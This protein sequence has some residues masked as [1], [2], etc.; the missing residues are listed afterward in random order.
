MCQKGTS[1]YIIRRESGCF[2]KIIFFYVLSSAI[3]VS[4]GDKDF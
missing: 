2:L 4:A 1:A 3:N